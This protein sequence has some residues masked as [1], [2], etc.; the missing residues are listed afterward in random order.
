MIGDGL[1]HD[2]TNTEFCEYDGGDCCL[3]QTVR[4]HLRF[5]FQ[6][7]NQSYMYVYP[8]YSKHWPILSFFPNS[9]RL[10]WP[11]LIV[12]ESL[13][14]LEALL[15]LNL[16]LKAEIKILNGFYDRQTLTSALNVCAIKLDW[17]SNLQI[18]LMWNE[19]NGK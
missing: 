2:A 4:T 10:E 5:E 3:P 8:K 9:R 6:H 1:C 7:S 13:E 12:I 16:N 17:A 18:L 14:Y 19:S 11:G 15:Y